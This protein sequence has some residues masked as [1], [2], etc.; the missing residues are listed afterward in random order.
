VPAPTGRSP[1]PPEKRPA[2]R[3]FPGSHDRS[4]Y[5][6]GMG[7][8]R[9]AIPERLVEPRETFRLESPFSIEESHCARG[10]RHAWLYLVRRKGGS[11]A[12]RSYLGNGET[13][14]ARSSET[15]SPWPARVGGKTLGPGMV[16]EPKL[17]RTPSNEAPPVGFASRGNAQNDIGRNG[18]RTLGEDGHRIEA[19]QAAARAVPSVPRRRLD[20]GRRGLYTWCASSHFERAALPGLD[21]RGS[22]GRAGR[23]EARLIWLDYFAESARL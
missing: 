17:R 14:C 8:A 3:C 9:A 23:L 12:R 18:R 6:N 10:E 16:S 5:H 4:P 21:R 11:S 7:A 15:R 13:A 1:S 2:L 22:G 20:G 19:G